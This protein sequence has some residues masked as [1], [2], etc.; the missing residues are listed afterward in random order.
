MKISMTVNMDQ[1]KM[2]RQKRKG[3][4]E[5]SIFL[6]TKKEEKPLKQISF[7]SASNDRFGLGDG[8]D[9]GTKMCYL[10]YRVQPDCYLILETNNTNCK[11]PC[12]ME[13][14]DTELHHFISC[15][16]WNCELISTTT[17]STTSTSGTSSP[18]PKPNKPSDMSALMYTSIVINIFFFAIL[19]AFI[20]GKFRAWMSARFPRAP[21]NAPDPNLYFSLGEN[22]NEDF[23]NETDP[24]ISSGAGG[25]ELVRHGS[26]NLVAGNVNAVTTHA[27]I[28]SDFAIENANVRGELEIENK[29]QIQDLQLALP[30]TSNWDAISLA[31]SSPDSSVP[32]NSKPSAPVENS[33]F[34][35]MKK[36]A[37]K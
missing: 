10:E 1:V 36:K 21:I 20:I 17:R 35:F 2:K 32:T 19:C 4:V 12:L 7:R 16:V 24:L 37:K 28:E 34:Q 33:L 5:S 25:N 30:S 6:V 22:R 14:C 15:P 18:R 13:G 27:I 8:I 3:K 23:E 29:N 11:I 26:T 31:S 9:C